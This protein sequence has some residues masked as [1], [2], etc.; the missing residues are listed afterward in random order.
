MSVGAQRAHVLIADARAARPRRT[1][2]LDD[3]VRAL[4]QPLDGGASALVGEVECDAAL[5]PVERQ[6][7]GGL[8]AV[9]WR[10]P[11]ARLVARAG[12]LDLDH[13]GAEIGEEHRAIRAREDPREVEHP[14]PRERQARLAAASGTWP[15][16][17][18]RERRS[19]AG[20]ACVEPRSPCAI[21]SAIMPKCSSSAVS[22]GETAM[23]RGQRAHEH[24]RL[25]GGHRPLPTAPGSARARLGRQ[26]HRGQQ[27]RR[28]REPRPQ[29]RPRPAA[30]RLEQRA[31]RS[32][33]RAASSPSRSSRPDVGDRRRAAG[34]M[35]RRRSA[36][37]RSTGPPG[38]LQ[39]GSA[40]RSETTT[41]PSGR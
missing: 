17:P 14:D 27:C 15:E 6:V 21:A 9:E 25:A 8:A 3:D 18:A 5:A 33:A 38:A 40:T 2:V 35:A 36:P 11:G 23:P 22:G 4:H 10:P 28:R 13:V 24:A 1:E 30:Q 37:W 20:G 41:P 12:P 7:V 32:L 16:S 39:N 26:L 19:S 29:P 31:A 34:G